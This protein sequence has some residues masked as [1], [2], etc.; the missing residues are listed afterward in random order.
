[1]TINPRLTDAFGLELSQDDLPFAIP[2]LEYDVPLGIDPFLLWASKVPDYQ[3][4]HAKLL[5]FFDQVR[6]LAL[7]GREAAAYQM[8]AKCGEV[9]ELGLGYGRTSKRGTALGPRLTR[10]IVELFSEI[11]QLNESGL[12]HTEE[13]QLL[14]PNV[15]E[16]RICDIAASVLKDWFIEFTARQAK[17]VGFPTR[18]Y[19]LPDVYDHDNGRWLPGVRA[20][21]PYNP[22]DESP[23]IFAPLDMLRHLPW[24]NYG[25][26]YR[27]EFSRNV[28]PPRASRDRQDKETV[29]KMNRANYDHVRRYV[30][31]KELNAAQCKPDP[32]FIPLKAETLSLR[33]AEVRALMPGTAAGADRK[34][35]DGVV[36]LLTSMFHPE[37]DLA[38]EQ[39]R[40]VDGTHIRDLVFYN[41]SKTEFLRE[42]RRSYDCRQIVFEMKN[43]RQVESEHVN[44]IYRYMDAN[45]GRVGFIVTR[46]PPPK[47]VL[48]NTVDLYLSK[49]AVVAFLHDGDLELMTHVLASGRRPVEVL[50]KKY[51]E[52]LNL[53]PK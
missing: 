5:A 34:Y 9:P 43:V 48:K 8:V 52:F 24:I 26:Y 29:L 12:D 38:E 40:T 11:P 31:A 14:V 53:I 45:T 47:A 7:A 44:Q 22:L 50:R 3:E 19:L 27:S 15:A 6:K 18:S 42:L 46:L 2:H 33:Y 17:R 25:D 37:L 32:F 20:D 10:D 28:L 13:L 23:L 16:D 4:L 35:E 51:S 1:M 49:R 41:D 30:R 21:L 39:V 36:D